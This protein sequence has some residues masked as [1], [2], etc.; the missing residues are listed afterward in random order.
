VKVTLKQGV[1]KVKLKLGHEHC[2]DCGG[3][4]SDECPTCY[5]LGEIECKTCDGQ[6]QL[7][8]QPNVCSA[9]WLDMSAEPWREQVC[10]RELSEFEKDWGYQQCTDHRRQEQWRAGRLTAPLQRKVKAS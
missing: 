8:I 5:G 9:T 2:E 1:V 6:G 4:G 10:D 3:D 7:P